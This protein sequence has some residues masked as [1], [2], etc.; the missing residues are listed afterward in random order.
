MTDSAGTWR[1]TITATYLEFKSLPDV[2]CS[3]ET[4]A[5]NQWANFFVDSDV[6]ESSRGLEYV[7]LWRDVVEK[8]LRLEL[9]GQEKNRKSY[10]AKMASTNQM[11]RATAVSSFTKWCDVSYYKFVLT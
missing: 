9:A 8:S 3:G 11:T 1:S 6:Y 7:T 4:N 2:R 10:L 5:R